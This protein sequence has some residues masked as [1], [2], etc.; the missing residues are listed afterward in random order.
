VSKSDLV[1]GDRILSVNG[2][3]VTNSTDAEEV[4]KIIREVGDDIH[5]VVVSVVQPPLRTAALDDMDQHMGRRSSADQQTSRRSSKDRDLHIGRRN[6]KKIFAEL[7]EADQMLRGMLGGHGEFLST[8]TP[9][10]SAAMSSTPDR[11]RGASTTSAARAPSAVSGPPPPPPL[12]PPPPP[13]P[14]PSLEVALTAVAD[15]TP[16]R[17]SMANMEELLAGVTLRT[18]AESSTPVGTDRRASLLVSLGD[19]ESARNNLRKTPIEAK[20][21][22]LDTSPHAMLELAL[23]AALQNRR[24]AVHRELFSAEIENDEESWS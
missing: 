4:I 2:M 15:A 14:P 7:Q 22:T 9:R 21:P 5:L 19:L 8:S 3:D 18:A 17:M 10:H 23:S 13:P 16:P 6:S 1:E 20:T 12:V 11:D 24:S